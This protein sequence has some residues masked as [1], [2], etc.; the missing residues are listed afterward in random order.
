MKCEVC[1]GTKV[2]FWLVP[3][4]TKI[5]P[6]PCCSQEAAEDDQPGAR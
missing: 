6:C 2:M 1:E 3:G 5:G 4:G